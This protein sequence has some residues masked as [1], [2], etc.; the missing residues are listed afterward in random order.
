M[1]FDKCKVCGVEAFMRCDKH[2]KCDGC[3]K[4]RKECE[5]KEIHL[6]HR[7]EGLFCSDCWNKKMKERIEEFSEDTSYKDEITCPYCGYKEIDSWEFSDEESGEIECNDCGNKLGFSTHK[8]IN[9]STEKLE[10]KE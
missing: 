5:D 10:E 6:I 1:S 2:N 4:T 3:G 7:C 8:D 9:Y